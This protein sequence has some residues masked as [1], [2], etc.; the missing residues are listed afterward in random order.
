LSRFAGVSG[1]VFSDDPI[2]GCPDHPILFSPLPA[3]LSQRPHPP[4]RFVE[5]KSQTPIRKA[6]QKAVE[7]L[8][9]RF[10]EL[11]SR[12]ISALF[13]RFTVRSAEGHNP[14]NVARRN[15]RRASTCH[16]ERLGAARESNDPN[17]VPNM[18]EC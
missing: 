10:S 1:L 11:Q 3:S 9:L 12:S 7:A 13:S 18:A 6:F 8:F 15:N 4:K 17:P 14:V 2:T 16:R 5:N